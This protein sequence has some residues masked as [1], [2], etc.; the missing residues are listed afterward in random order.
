[1]WGV[2]PSEFWRMCPAEWWLIYDAKIGEPKYGGMPESDVAELY[3]TL[4]KAVKKRG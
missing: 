1:M 3:D 4:E 2:Q